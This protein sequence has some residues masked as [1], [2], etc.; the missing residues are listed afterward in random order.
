MLMAIEEAYFASCEAGGVS[1]PHIL[2][3]RLKGPDE[4]PS[5]QRAARSV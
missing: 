5:P 1:F 3:A 2:Q 4:L